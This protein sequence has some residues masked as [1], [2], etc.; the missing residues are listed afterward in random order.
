LRGEALAEAYANM[1][2]FTFP[3]RTDTF[4]NVVLEAFASARPAVVTNAGG[5]KFIVRDGTSGFVADTDGD[6]IERTTRLLADA[7]LR[8]RMG[9]AARSQAC[10][11]SWDSVFEQVYDGY[12]AGIQARLAPA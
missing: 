4:G 8:E 12:R 7:G 6:F 5:P 10:G 9:A 1:D 11:E 3:S 2:V